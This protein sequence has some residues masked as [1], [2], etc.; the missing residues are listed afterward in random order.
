MKTTTG[1]GGYIA[2]VSISNIQM[3]NTEKA[4]V[5][6]GFSGEHPDDKWNPQAYPLVE[7]IWIQNV[8]G[9]N[10]MQAGEL[11]G[12]QEAPFQRICLINIALDVVPGRPYW[13]CSEVA[14]SSSFVLPKPCPELQDHKLSS[15]R[16]WVESWVVSISIL[17]LWPFSR[18]SILWYF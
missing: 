11:L 1:R 9:E 5:F 7:R 18:L 4:I 3:F 14:G 2:N 12:L 10:I 13:N 16:T 6:S 15:S 8:V 17:C